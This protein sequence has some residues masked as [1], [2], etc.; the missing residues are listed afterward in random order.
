MMSL[1]LGHNLMLRQLFLFGETHWFRPLPHTEYAV[2]VVFICNKGRTQWQS[3]W[4]ACR[5]SQVHR[6]YFQGWEK[7]LSAKISLWATEHYHLLPPLCA[8]YI[9]S[10]GPPTHVR[11]KGGESFCISRT[12]CTDGTDYFKS[13]ELGSRITI[14]DV[15]WNRCDRR[16]HCLQLMQTSGVW[17]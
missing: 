15:L 12:S 2:S 10:R 7:V 4:F 9:C 3:N 6:G 8:P 14:P 13:H 1:E 11:E 16:Q 5:S 17:Y